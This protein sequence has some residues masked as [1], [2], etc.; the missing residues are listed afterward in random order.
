MHP[1]FDGISKEINKIQAG[2]VQ[3]EAHPHR[4][5]GGL[6]NRHMHFGLGVGV[7]LHLTIQRH[8]AQRKPPPHF[9]MPSC[10]GLPLAI[11][12]IPLVHCIVS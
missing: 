6:L 10:H 2:R 4:E 12:N 9:P 3:I 5:G 11:A 1:R 8:T 7:F